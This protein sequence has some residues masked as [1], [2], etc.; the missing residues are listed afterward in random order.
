MMPVAYR[1]YPGRQI[2]SCTEKNLRERERESNLHNL[3]HPRA[4]MSFGLS[5]LKSFGLRV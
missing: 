5:A 4:H 2:Q 1:V 3:P